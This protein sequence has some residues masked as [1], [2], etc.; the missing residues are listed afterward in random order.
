MTPENCNFGQL[1]STSVCFGKKNKTIEP[2]GV[3]LVYQSTIQPSPKVK[4]SGPGP[5]RGSPNEFP[6]LGN[7]AQPELQGEDV[8]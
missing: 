7:W 3:L 6:P 1:Y 2:E 8:G 5:N 4:I